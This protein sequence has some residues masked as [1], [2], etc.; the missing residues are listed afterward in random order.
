M[1]AALVVVA[2]GLAWALWPADAPPPRQREYRAETACLLT[3]EKGVAEPE[4]APVWAG[5]QE[6]SVATH[7]KIQYL[8]VNGPQTAENAETYLASL[9]QSRCDLILSAGPGPVGALRAGAARFPTVHFVGI[10]GGT[11]AS[12]VSVVEAKSP[13]VAQ[14]KAREL[15]AGLAS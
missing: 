1:V 3:G 14:Q 5:M 12:N 13:Q 10:N 8:E 11:A 6:A 2:G 4:A 7:V 15:I 9:V